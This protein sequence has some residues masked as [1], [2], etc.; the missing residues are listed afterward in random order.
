MTTT[1]SLPNVTEYHTWKDLVQ[2]MIQHTQGSTDQSSQPTAR[3]YQLVEFHIFLKSQLDSFPEEYRLLKAGKPVPATS[4][5]LTLTSEF[6]ETS[7]LI[8][9]GGHLRRAE[10]M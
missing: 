10:R 6:D 8:Q 9:V 2:A 1:P 5:L 4:R 3:D 7:Q